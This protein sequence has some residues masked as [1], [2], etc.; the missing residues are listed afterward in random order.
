[1]VED[2]YYHGWQQSGKTIEYAYDR[3]T[4]RAYYASTSHLGGL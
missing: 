4:G 2:G 3:K 1:M